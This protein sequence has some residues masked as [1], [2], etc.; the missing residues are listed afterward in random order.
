[1]RAASTI[2]MTGC[3]SAR[4]HSMPAVY[5]AMPAGREA[6]QT[7]R[8]MS[9]GSHVCPRRS[10]KGGD[11][12]STTARGRIVRAVRRRRTIQ[13]AVASLILVRA[14]EQPR[15][16]T[17]RTVSIVRRLTW[18]TNSDH[19]GRQPWIIWRSGGMQMIWSAGCVDWARLERARSRRVRGDRLSPGGWLTARPVSR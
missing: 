4:W 12:S 17:R 2:Q 15:F 3:S 14:A 7:G 9:V 16:L 1:M 6:E 10:N 8:A 5:S 18:K 19:C 11:G 13:T